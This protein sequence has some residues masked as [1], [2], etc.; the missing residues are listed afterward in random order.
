MF[1]TEEEAKEAILKY[2]K[3]YNKQPKVIKAKWMKENEDFLNE[4][5]LSDGIYDVTDIAYLDLHKATLEEIKEFTREHDNFVYAS[6]YEVDE[7]FLLAHGPEAIDTDK[8]DG[9]GFNYGSVNIINNC[10]KSILILA[11]ND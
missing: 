8:W 9:S 3:E 1:N 6:A 11:E 7:V 10:P 2:N 4:H 5:E